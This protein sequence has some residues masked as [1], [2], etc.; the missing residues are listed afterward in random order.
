MLIAVSKP[1]PV[2]TE[3]D[4]VD[5]VEHMLRKLPKKHAQV[6]RMQYLYGK[7]QT[8]IAAGARLLADRGHPSST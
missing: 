4:D 5:S 2:G 1:P 6:C 8:E 3:L 7:T